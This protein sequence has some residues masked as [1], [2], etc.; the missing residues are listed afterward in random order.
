M[1]PESAYA[2]EPGEPASPAQAS[3][4]DKVRENEWLTALSL[5]LATAPALL[6]DSSW[7][8]GDSV[9]AALA[10]LASASLAVKTLTDMLTVP[11]APEVEYALLVAA[12]FI[13]LGAQ[14]IGIVVGLKAGSLGGAVL[15]NVSL[16]MV[17]FFFASAALAIA[18]IGVRYESPS[19]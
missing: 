1:G 7:Q 5:F 16:F 4:A 12:Y 9:L 17:D 3:A 11:R 18:G 13:S 6:H 8:P 19:S 10:V 15:A 14:V 2:T